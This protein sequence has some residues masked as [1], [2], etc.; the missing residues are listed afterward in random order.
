MTVAL[1]PVPVRRPRRRPQGRRAGAGVPLWYPLPGS[2]AEGPH[3][4]KYRLEVRDPA[5]LV[6]P[7]WRLGVT[8]SFYRC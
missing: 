2:G 8:V 7:A 6:G 4:W 3:G 1:P 5:A